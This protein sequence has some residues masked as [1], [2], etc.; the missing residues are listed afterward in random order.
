MTIDTD[1]R[2]LKK[3]IGFFAI[4]K[5]EWESIKSIINLQII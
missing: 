3:H 2:R 1:N 4:R 5:G